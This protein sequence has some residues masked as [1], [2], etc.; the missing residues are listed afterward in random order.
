MFSTKS[1]RLGRSISVVFGVILAITL[2]AS[3]LAS[4]GLV[5]DRRVTLAQAKDMASKAQSDSGFPIV[6][7]DLVLTELNRFVGTPEGREYI[8]TALQRMETY[9]STV[10]LYL[11]K[12][13][14]PQEI[15]AVPIVESGYQNLAQR[16]SGGHGA[17]L[18]QFIPSTAHNFGLEVDHSRDERLE[19]GANTDAAMRYLQMNNLRFKDWALSLMAYNMGEKVLQHAIDVTGSRD[20]WTL[21]RRGYEGDH[22]Y[23][24]R[25]V[26]A[27]LIMK[28]P[29][30]VQ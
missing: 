29:E 13:G 19:I 21:V 12:Y 1:V 26:A 30:V 20:A 6:I 16:H 3:A 2:S 11:Q 22:A 18:W 25:V 23:L 28:N 5:Q 14:V 7:N 27:A 9:R 15:M 24:A 4:R 8:R 10:G 17:G